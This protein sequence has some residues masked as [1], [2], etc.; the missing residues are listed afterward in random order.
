[1]ASGARQEGIRCF[2]PSARLGRVAGSVPRSGWSDALGC[3]DI[4]YSEGR[5]ALDFY[6]R[7]VDYQ[8]RLDRSAVRES[9]GSGARER[10]IKERNLSPTTAEPYGI[11]LRLHIMPIIGR[12]T[13]G[14]V[15][16]E[17]VRSWR[18]WLL[19]NGRSQTTTA[20]AYRLLRAVMNTAYDDNRIKRNPCRI[21][22]A[23]KEQAPERTTATVAQVYALA[24]RMP[25][26]YRALVL[27]AA[28]SG[29]RWG[30]LIGLRRC[31]VDLE[32]GVIRV[33]RRLAQLRSGQLVAG[34][35]KSVAGLRA[36][37]LPSVLL[38]DLRAHLDEFVRPGEWALLFLGP[39]GG[40][41]M[42]G[43][44]RRSVNWSESVIAA[45]LPE[46]FHFHDL[47]HTGN[48]MAAEAGA[49][50]KEL[51]HRMGHGSV[52]AALIYQH[53]TDARDRAI[54]DSLSR[55]V[56]AQREKSAGDGPAA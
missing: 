40:E 15:S 33:T 46:G 12:I 37:A 9:D 45:G 43:N 53:A 4:R 17:L 5:R 13:L 22:G 20:K 11:L 48:Q 52:R 21:P 51:M 44:W 26:R 54:A 32:L 28:L 18:S 42:R 29:L 1:M 55:H 24:D 38:P 39:K 34:T 31:D 7:G 23:D 6:H 36:V 14:D 49:T 3:Y 16:S 27:A 19:E 35:T 10:S 8:G 41:L 30:E 2:L 56:E 47:R 50:T 25:R